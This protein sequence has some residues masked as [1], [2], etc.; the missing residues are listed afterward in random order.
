MNAMNAMLR[1]A[2]RVCYSALRARFFTCAVVSLAGLS[3]VAPGQSPDSASRNPSID[4]EARIDDLMKRMTPAEKARLLNPGYWGTK[5]VERLG[6]PPLKMVNGS[7]GIRSGR[8]TA[9]SSGVNLAAT[10]NPSLVRRVGIALGKEVRAKGH[11]TLLGPVIYMHR[12]PQGGRNAES[13][14]EDPHLAGRIAAAYIDGIQSQKVIATAALFGCKAHEYQTHY[15][16]ARV[17]ER[18]IHEIYLPAYKTAV[19]EGR[20]WAIMTAYNRVNG[21]LASN[22][23]YLLWDIVKQRWGFPGLIMT[24]WAGVKDFGAAVYAG[25]DLDMPYGRAYTMENLL[26]VFEG[27]S[28]KRST[29]FRPTG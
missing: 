15:F 3:S 16:D 6:I 7:Y 20:V 11:N 26:K 22:H 14:S 24:D 10:W 4:V 8:A 25:M 9:F 12:I 18:T 27:D 17:D 23:P 19:Q 5:P 28:H 21:T 2:A 13:F 1:D 29:R